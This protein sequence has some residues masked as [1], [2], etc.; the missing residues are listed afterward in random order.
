MLR[1]STKS[2]LKVQG[3][4]LDIANAMDVLPSPPDVTNITTLSTDGS[5]YTGS[6]A[7]FTGRRLYSS[8]VIDTADGSDHDVAE[9]HQKDAGDPWEFE[10]MSLPRQGRRLFQNANDTATV[11][12]AITTVTSTLNKLLATLQASATVSLTAGSYLDWRS[13]TTQI[14]QV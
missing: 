7:T 14:A 5:V 12:T 10:S 2:N 1:E 6:W 3:R 4:A 8:S 9:W 11:V 13:Y